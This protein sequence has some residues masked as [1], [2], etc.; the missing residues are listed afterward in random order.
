MGEPYVESGECIPP[1]QDRYKN[2]LRI[3]KEILEIYDKA[4]TDLTPQELEKVNKKLSELQEYGSPPQH[5]MDK[6]KGAEEPPAGE[7][8]S[9]EE[10]VKNMGLSSGLG[11]QEQEMIKQLSA[12]PDELNNIMK[13][14]AEE[15]QGNEEPCKQQ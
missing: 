5:I 10:F 15:I 11:E 14:M 2:Q 3:Y 7:D 8:D 13:Q 4:S 12:N 6:L 9:F 1:D